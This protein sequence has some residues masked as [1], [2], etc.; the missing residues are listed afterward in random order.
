MARKLKKGS[1]AWWKGKAWDQFSIYVRVRDALLTT[2]TTHSVICCTCGKIYPIRGKG[3]AQAGHFIPGRG[4]SV[5]FSERGVH[6]QCYHCNMQLKGNT[7]RY[8]LYMQK[9]YG[10]EVIDELL[11][12][13]TQPRKYYADEL[14]YMRDEYKR[15]HRLMFKTKT[16]H[17]FGEESCCS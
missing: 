9:K 8:L 17:L 10:Q 15:L 7:A 16:V 1:V 14:E 5:L 6:A 4:N 12:E 11:A 2:G 13:Y 3:T